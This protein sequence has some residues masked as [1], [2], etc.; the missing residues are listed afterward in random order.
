MGC[1][2]SKPAAPAGQQAPQATSQPK[3]APQPKKKLDPKDFIFSKRRGETLIKE[4][5]TIMGQQFNVEECEDCDI[6]LL[7]TIATIFIDEC[8]G[9]RIFVGPVESSVFLRN[10]SSCDVV[11]ACQQFR[12]RDCS[13][14]RCALLCTTEPIIETSQNMRFA[15]FDFFYFSLREQLER[16]KIKVWNNKW[17]QVHDFNKNPDKP[18]WD[19]LP[20]AEVATLLRTTQCT[21]ITEEELKMDKVVPLTLGSRP[22]PSQESAF[23]IFLP[24]LEEAAGF[25]GAFLT[26]A[27]STE[28]WNLCRARSVILADDR[29]KSLLGWTKEKNLEAR[30]KGKEVAGIEVCGMG[31]HAKV[32]ETLN[33]TGFAAATKCVRLVPPGD[34]KGLAK[35]FFDVWK[36]EI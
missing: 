5:G 28:G 18:N 30:C 17:W 13:D 36:D 29:V 9:C 31:I 34:T 12:S 4:D 33:S 19:L 1:G 3:A 14:C 7:D 21:S 23:V 26:Q 6:F 11:I 35:A 22:W 32:Q 2:S 16:A 10:C 8:K 25:I 15:C 24:P 27:S 20:Q